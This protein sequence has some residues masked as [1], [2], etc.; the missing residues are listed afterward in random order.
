[1][2]IPVILLLISVIIVVNTYKTHGDIVIK[3]VS[4]TGGVTARIEVNADTEKLAKSLSEKLNQEVLVKKISNFG[5]EEATGIIIETSEIEISLLEAA[6]EEELK[7][8]LNDKN[9]SAEQTGSSLGK[10]FYKQMIKAVLFAFLLMAITVLI[11]FRSFIPAIAVVGAAFFD[12]ITTIATLDIL[13]I[14]ISTAGIAALLLLIGYSI[15]T[16]VLLTT[17]VLK[18]QGELKSKIFSSIKTGMTMTFTTLAALTVGAIAS[19]AEIIRQMFI[20]IIIGLLFDMISTWIVNVYIIKKY[21][22]RRE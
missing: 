2:V 3:D 20:I 1:M 5:S 9:Y 18:R 16:D 10:S 13:E 6:I 7:I 4:L 11:A 8:E 14:K 17:R 22:E 21:V 19:N 15:D 12:L